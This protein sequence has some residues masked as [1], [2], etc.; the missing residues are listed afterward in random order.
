[1]FDNLIITGSNKIIQFL[2]KL[3]LDIFLTEPQIKHVM[4]FIC[5]M[6]LKV[7]ICVYLSWKTQ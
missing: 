5:A 4:A 1:M 2:H 6:V 3:D 7:Y